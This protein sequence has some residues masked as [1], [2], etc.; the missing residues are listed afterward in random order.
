MID[1]ALF[2]YLTKKSGHTMA[3]AAEAMGFSLSGL[4]RRLSGGTEFRRDE[5]EAWMLLCGVTDAGPVFF[6]ANVAQT[7]QPE[8]RV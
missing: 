6:P 1:R 2:E 3:E 8:A 4:S 5:M 7:Q